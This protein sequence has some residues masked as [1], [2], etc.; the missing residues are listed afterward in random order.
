MEN[1][2]F[3]ERLEK[4]E[5]KKA[6]SNTTISEAP[7]GI[8]ISTRMVIG[9]ILVF[10]ACGGVYLGITQYSS[11]L[12]QEKAKIIEEKRLADL[13]EKSKLEKEAALQDQ[14]AKQ[15]AEI[16]KLKSD[17]LTA[18][19][20][21][22]VLEKSIKSVQQKPQEISISALELA[23]YLSG[24][25]QIKCGDISGS[26]SLWKSE[27]GMP[28]YAALTNEHV[29][30]GLTGNCLL[31]PGTDSFSNTDSASKIMATADPQQTYKWN[32]F[33]DIAVLSVS[34]PFTMKENCE[35]A[36]SEAVSKEKL[37]Y[38]IS[39][40]KKCPEKMPV[41][42][43]IVAV[44]FPAFGMTSDIA[45]HRISSNGIISGYNTRDALDRAIPYSNYFTSAKI[46]SG[47][48]GGIAFSKTASGL[49]VLGVPTWVSVGNYETNGLIQNI[50]NV[51]YK[52]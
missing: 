40:L 24:V 11:H 12:T 51:M 9:A 22:Q 16:E 14:L 50:H 5:A 42:S 8:F 18:K 23:P 48:S 4:I 15:Q 41:G 20:G 43:P 10:V 44:G 49:C 39:L 27:S 30:E 25:M 28:T 31:F 7:R 19:Q 13:V 47:N 6:S 45:S 3:K 32:K 35:G 46:D 2:K 38:S 37:N 26:V 1:N 36:C 34:T 52:N 21:Q 29:V 33:T 17:S